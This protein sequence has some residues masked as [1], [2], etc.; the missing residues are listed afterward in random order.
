MLNSLNLQSI[1]C[2]HNVEMEAKNLIFVNS[3]QIINSRNEVAFRNGVGKNI[4]AI[5]NIFINKAR[6]NSIDN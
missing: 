2:N 3:R 1:H 4:E 6:D 5:S